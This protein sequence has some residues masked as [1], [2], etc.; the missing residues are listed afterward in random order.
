MSE[1]GYFC[2][3]RRQQCSA[4]RRVTQQQA[5]RYE[6]CIWH[7]KGSDSSHCRAVGA[8]ASLGSRDC[9]EIQLAPRGMGEKVS[10]WG[11]AKNHFTVTLGHWGVAGGR[12]GAIEHDGGSGGDVCGREP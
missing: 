12:L 11:W 9:L 3:G 6:T 2:C 1:K 10:D 7:R 8:D 4:V 5:A